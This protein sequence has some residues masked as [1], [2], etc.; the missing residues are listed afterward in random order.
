MPTELFPF[1]VHISPVTIA[2]VGLWATTFYLGFFPWGEWLTER[3][4]R[5]FNAAERSLYFSAEE[6]EKTR[7]A[8]ESQNAFWASVL[9][10]L[11]F[12][13]IG[14]LSYFGLIASLGASWAISGGLIACIGSGVYELGRRD[15]EASRK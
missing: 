4:S 9:S 1:P 7:S 11:P 14:A 13:A 15:G 5:W 6:F 2:G 3:L 12:L 8:R 10:I